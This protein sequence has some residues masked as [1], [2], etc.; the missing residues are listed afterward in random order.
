M[1]QFSGHLSGKAKALLWK[2]DEKM[3][4]IYKKILMLMLW[5]IPTSLL[6]N[7]LCVLFFDPITLPTTSFIALA[8][9]FIGLFEKSFLLLG[10][11]VVLQV[12]LV[13]TGFAVKN[14]QGVL[15][16]VTLLYFCAEV[17]YILYLF[18]DSTI[19]N[20]FLEDSLYY[21]PCLILPTAMI[22]LLFRYCIEHFKTKR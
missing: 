14:R 9:S 5:I 15:P 17:V 13:L 7:L 6:V 10:I 3:R 16:C 11:S 4:E 21:L 19:K 20:T 18:I 8:L 12:L 2:R 22:Y 1:I